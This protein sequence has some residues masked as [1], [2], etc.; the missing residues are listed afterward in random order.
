MT[1]HELAQPELAEVNIDADGGD[2]SRSDVI[3]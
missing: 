2:L 3:L 1:N